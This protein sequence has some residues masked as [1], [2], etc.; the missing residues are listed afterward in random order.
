MSPG[1]FTRD[2]TRPN[3]FLKLV[4]VACPISVQKKHLLYFFG[5]TVSLIF[6]CISQYKVQ[7]IVMVFLYGILSFNFVIS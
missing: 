1:K 4:L 5:Y 6:Y 2:K 7:Y 3:C